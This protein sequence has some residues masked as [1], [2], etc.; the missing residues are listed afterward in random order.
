M[1]RIRLG[2]QGVSMW[3]PPLQRAETKPP[4]R[5]KI[6]GWTKGAAQ[7]NRAF[8]MSVDP[9][10]LAHDLGY[11]VTLTLGATPLSAA[12]WGEIVHHLLVTLRRWGV[13][14]FHWVTEWT[15]RGRPHLHLT[16]FLRGREPVAPDIAALLLHP[17]PEHATVI[18]ARAVGDWHMPKPRYRRA[19]YDKI[20]GPSWQARPVTHCIPQA[21][22]VTDAVIANAVYVAWQRAAAP[23]PCDV[24]AQHIERIEALSGWQAYVAKHCARGITH[25]QRLAT[26]LP[27]GWTSSGRLWG[28]GGNWPA[29]SDNLELDDT[30]YFRLR[31]VLR[32]WLLAKAKF[33]AARAFGRK[34]DLARQDLKYLRK[35]GSKKRAESEKQRD[36]KTLSSVFGLSSFVPRDML[37]V[38]LVWAIDHPRA[39]LIDADTGEVHTSND[40]SDKAIYDQF[41]M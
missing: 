28:K 36:K 34:Q 6:S 20:I 25:Y 21:Q 18:K 40:A 14:R 30:S 37:D 10:V 38:L 41:G 29:R 11:A 35:A 3:T 4:K 22:W 24:R 7:R 16:F 12:I 5:K 32:K 2:G 9:T 15:T 17:S 13:V 23:L 27:K 8:L 1:R 26:V 33:N 31:R 39:V 19:F